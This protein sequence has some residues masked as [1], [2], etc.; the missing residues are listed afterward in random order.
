MKVSRSQIEQT[1]VGVLLQGGTGYGEECVRA[2]QLITAWEAL[3]R[4]G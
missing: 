2:D 3:G 1:A 4:V